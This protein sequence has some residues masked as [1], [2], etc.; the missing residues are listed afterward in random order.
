MQSLT[1]N[2][3]EQHT[4]AKKGCLL[5]DYRLLGHFLPPDL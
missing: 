4:I 5:G 1:N 2:F 3:N